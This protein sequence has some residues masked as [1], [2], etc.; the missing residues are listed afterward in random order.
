MRNRLLEDDLYQAT[1]L[2]MTKRTCDTKSVACKI[3]W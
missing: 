3:L 2:Q 1:W